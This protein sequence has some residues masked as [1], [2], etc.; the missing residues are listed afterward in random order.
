MSKALKNKLV[1]IINFFLLSC[2]YCDFMSESELEK[3][4][5]LP[6]PLLVFIDL[7]REHLFDKSIGSSK[8]CIKLP[9]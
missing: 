9:N 3:P 8:Q 1:L 5:D 6:Q 2:K 7:A 4:T